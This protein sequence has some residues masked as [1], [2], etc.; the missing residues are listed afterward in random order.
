MNTPLFGLNIDPASAKL[1]TAL[2]LASMADQSAVDLIT[3]QDHPYN[4]DFLDTWTLLTALAAR[5]QRV[6]LMTNVLN[7]PLR[8]PAVFAKMAA[9]LDVISA[10]R[11]Q[12]GIG[13]GGY[14]EGMQ[15][16]GGVVGA[17]AGDRFAAFTEYIDILQGMLFGAGRPFSYSG[18]FYQ[19][20]DVVNGPKPV[21][22]IPIWIGAGRAR[23][24]RFA[25]ARGDGWLIGT[26]YILPE[27]LDEVNQY[28]DEGARQAGRNPEAVRRGYNLFG[29]IQTGPA[30]RFRFNR[31]GLIVGSAEQWVETMA[32][33]HQRYRH[34][35]FIFWPVAGNPQEQAEVFL[36]QVLP[37][38][39][40]QIQTEMAEAS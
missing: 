39:R 4:P 22:R 2:Q 3:I 18:R 40:Q 27:G 23:M 38:A 33:Y 30:D 14:T 17:S 35:T 8:P 32:H 15:A 7:S 16:W 31:P 10:G 21:H 36:N 24:L 9:T 29:V 5:T 28:L 12:L 19:L 37:Q 20:Q 26:T 13:A 11:L 25:G 34:D 6:Q 1:Q